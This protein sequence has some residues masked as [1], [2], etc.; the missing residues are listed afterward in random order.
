MKRLLCIATLL[1]LLLSGCSSKP[2]QQQFFAMDTVMSVTACGKHSE[3][4]VA[5]AVARVNELEGL[6]SR[7]RT[8]SEVTAL[9]LAAPDAVPLSEDTLRVL[10]LAQEWHAKTNGAFDVT[11]APVTTAWGFGGSGDYQ[12]PTPEKLEKLLPLVDGSSV[13]LTE[14]AAALPV[15]GMEIDLGGIAKG[16]A[17]SQAEEVLRANGIESALLDL[18]RNITVIGTKPNGRDW[19]V[20][21]QDPADPDGV[22]GVLSLHDCSVVTSGGYQRYFEQDGTVYHHIID[23]RTGYPANSGL[24]SATVVCADSA[25]ADLLSTAVFVLGED[26]ALDLWRAEGGFEL[27]LVT[28]DGRAVVT[29]GLSGRFEANEHAAYRTE[30]VS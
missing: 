1:L 5:A 14:T 7:T 16:Y 2:V 9:Y 8:N 4:A 12:V 21:V 24:I 13:V 30:Y 22:V 20:A 3:T 11:I 26:A 15:K 6:L 17:A 25:L 19:R 29:A 10:T 23:P 27:I 18:G 28:D